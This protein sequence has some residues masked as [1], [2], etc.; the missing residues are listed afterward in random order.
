MAGYY[1][2]TKSGKCR[3]FAS[4]GT[5]PSGKRKRPTKTVEAKSD[6]EASKLLAKFVSEVEKGE[7]VEPS[8]LTFSVFVER[9]LRDYAEL[10]LAPKTLYRYKQILDTRI[11][12]A[13]GHLKIEQIKPTHLLEFY[14]NLQ[15]DGIREDGK[16]GG[17]SAKTILQ[18]HRIISSILNDAVQWQVTGSNP[19]SRVKPPRV[20]TKQ[21]AY[22]DED[23][24]L[25][26][27]EALDSVELKYKTAVILAVA[28]GLRRGE[29]MGLEWADVDFNKGTLEVRQAGQYLPGKGIF[30]KEPKNETS[31]RIIAVSSSVIALLRK[32]KAH[33]A[34][35]RLEAGDLWRGSGVLSDFTEMFDA[36]TPKEIS[37]A[38]LLKSLI[39]QKAVTEKWE[40]NLQAI[41]D[42]VNN[43]EFIQELR[44]FGEKAAPEI[45]ALKTLTDEQLKEYIL[46]YKEKNKNPRGG[47]VFTTWDGRP[48]H[49]DTLSSWFPKFIKTYNFREAFN[50]EISAMSIKL[51]EQDLA[52]L[53]KLKEKYLKLNISSLKP[54]KEKLAAVEDSIIKI[55]GQESFE[56]IQQGRKLPPLPFHGLRHTSITMLIAQGIP[57][58]NVSRRAGHAATSTT[59]NIY[60][61]ALKSID[62]DAAD[63][64]DQVLNRNNKEKEQNKKQA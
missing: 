14:A 31:K 10:N 57:L 50:A 3:L 52:I 21:A 41:A 34:E 60:A 28:T 56:R 55:I 25:A 27:M 42:Q 19:A 61:H 38:Q 4:A 63:K 18:H 54:K 15:E 46:I 62:R 64:L 43:E 1:E 47:R 59:A 26:L 13:M 53:E 37:G 16:P 9:W 23:Q 12:P 39:K 2:W 49:P 6:R 36:V 8:K 40:E 17:L 35:E 11:L 5:G 24:T 33:Q 29:L 7:Y 58:P 51:S 45:A 30:T 44:K 32:H 48:M 22:Y 20:K